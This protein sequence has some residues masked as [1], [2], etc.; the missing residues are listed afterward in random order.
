[1]EEALSAGAL[2]SALELPMPPE[3]EYDR[4]GLVEA[5]QPLKGTD[6]PLPPISEMKE[7][8]LAGSAGSDFRGGRAADSP[9]HVSHMKC[10]GRKTG[11]GLGENPEAV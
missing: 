11:A 7:M 1:M 10:I 8:E 4:D 9:L 5:L 3:F 2:E 6:I